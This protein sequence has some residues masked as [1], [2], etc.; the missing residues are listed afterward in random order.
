MNP[1][2]GTILPAAL[3]NDSLSGAYT[4]T[5]PETAQRAALYVRKHAGDDAGM[6]LAMLGIG[7]RP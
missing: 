1:I 6:L 7:G 2:D 4:P 5:D 3:D